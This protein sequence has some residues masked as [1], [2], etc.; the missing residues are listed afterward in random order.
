MYSSSNRAR[1]FI[2]NVASFAGINADN[3]DNS[4]RQINVIVALPTQ[5]SLNIVCRIPKVRIM[6]NKVFAWFNICK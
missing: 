2:F 5:K 6:A 1:E 3:A 4:E